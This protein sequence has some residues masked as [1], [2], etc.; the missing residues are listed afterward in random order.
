MNPWLIMLVPYFGRWPEW[1][2]LFVESCR[3]N[4]GVRWRF[5]TDC[6]E[7][8]NQ[9]DNVD[10]VHLSFDDYK[11]LVRERLGIAFD[12]PAPYKLCDLRPCLAYIH[13]RDVAGFPFFGYGDV[14]VIYG[15]IGNFYTDDVLARCNVLS[16]HP[17]R[18][19]GHFAVLRNTRDFRHAFER[20]PSYR[21]LLEQP[22]Y[23]NMDEGD[24][25]DVFSPP[26]AGPH[27]SHGLLFVER[28]S[29]VLSPRGWHDGT[30]KYPQQWFWQRGRLTNERDGEREFLYLHF[31]RWQSGRWMT[32]RP[33]P[34]EAAWL[35][36]ERI[37]QVDWH[38]AAAEGFCIGPEGFTDI[39]PRAQEDFR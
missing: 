21:T 8:E 34:G 11:A 30:M 19:S 7:P 33:A 22:Q 35:R 23:A 24:F 5:Y 1:M 31:M 3:W 15:N 17:E 2:N 20:I 29:T 27:D 10:Y 4:P 6:G 12:P 18:L 9:A 38:R 36:L 28:Y 26:A 13:E 25:S 14:D 37:V 39:S 32:D 16:T